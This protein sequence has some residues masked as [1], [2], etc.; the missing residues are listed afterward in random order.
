[1]IRAIATLSTV[2][3]SA[4]QAWAAPCVSS[5]FDVPFPGA[6]DVMSHVTDLP[7]SIFPAFWQEGRL[8]G[9]TYKIFANATGVLRSADAD[10]HWTI[11]VS[12]DVSNE[13]CAFS[14]FGYPPETAARVAERVGECLVFENL[15]PEAPQE[16]ITGVADESNN[17]LAV[18]FPA[19]VVVDPAAETP[20][21]EPSA[22]CGTAITNESTD[23]A[24]MQRLLVLL[25]KDPGP[26]DGFLGPQTFTA[27][28]AFVSN[29]GWGSP[30]P[31]LVIVLSELHCSQTQ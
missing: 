18:T 12:C 7:S 25:G 14:E 4:T 6:T 5:T 20:T 2:A 30:I 10:Q 8:D 29:P 26:V 31:E 22:A 1:M 15:V 16:L 21:S 23:I 17:D 11:E 9:Y 27:M 19:L 28:E 3:A 13:T 24:T